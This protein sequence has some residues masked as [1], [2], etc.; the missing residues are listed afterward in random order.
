MCALVCLDDAHSVLGLLER[1]CARLM[2]YDRISIRFEINGLSLT[3]M[4]CVKREKENYVLSA[5]ES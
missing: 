1:S 2:C 3:K 4:T 5:F